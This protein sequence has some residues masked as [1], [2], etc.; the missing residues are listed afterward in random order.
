MALVLLGNQRLMPFDVTQLIVVLTNLSHQ[1]T[2]ESGPVWGWGPLLSFSWEMVLR[3][4]APYLVLFKMPGM[5]SQSPPSSVPHSTATL[6]PTPPPAL[7]TSPPLG[8]EAATG[9]VSSWLL[10]SQTAVA[11]R[12]PQKHTHTPLFSVTELPGLPHSVSCGSLA[13]L[14]R[15]RS[16][17]CPIA[18]PGRQTGPVWGVNMLCGDGTVGPLSP[19][20]AQLEQSKGRLWVMY[21]FVCFVI[22]C[23]ACLH[24]LLWGTPSAF[25]LEETKPRGQR[26]PSP[27]LFCSRPCPGGDS[28]ACS[29]AKSFSSFCVVTSQIKKKQ[30]KVQAPSMFAKSDYPD[31]GLGTGA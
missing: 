6:T 1:K 8:D 3:L 4:P 21:W 10:S 19:E 25:S 24:A 18:A 14:M 29:V 30:T 23:G 16:T 28:L 22:L 12:V 2:L 15:P 9:Q 31:R 11:I 26:C 13:A 17:F 5:K 27:Q 20:L 7:G